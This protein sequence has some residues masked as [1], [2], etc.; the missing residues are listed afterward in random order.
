MQDPRIEGYLVFKSSIWMRIWGGLD[1][2]YLFGFSVLQV[3]YGKVPFY[4]DLLASHRTSM[5]YGSNLPEIMS[6]LSILFYA[7]L[8]ASGV[9]LVTRSRF[10]RYLAWMQ[11]IPRFVFFAP[12]F[13]LIIVLV[14]WVKIFWIV[15]LIFGISEAFKMYTLEKSKS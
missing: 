14:R 4:S 15:M 1:L 13:L 10:G 3:L 6:L 11:L 8:I 7:S 2:L 9:L 12:S 5:I